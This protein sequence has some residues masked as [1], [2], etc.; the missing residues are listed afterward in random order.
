M[1]GLFNTV[2]WNNDPNQQRL[3]LMLLEGAKYDVSRGSNGAF[4]NIRE[5]IAFTQQCGWSDKEASNQFIHAVSM[6]KPMVDPNLYSA[7]KAIGQN[8]YNAYRA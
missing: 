6:L 5:M 8:L 3:A 4:L 1:F 7:A 2:K